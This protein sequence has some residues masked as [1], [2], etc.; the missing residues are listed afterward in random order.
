M[1]I[2]LRS[3]SGVALLGLLSLASVLH[4]AS[5]WISPRPAV[6]RALLEG[7]GPWLPVALG[8]GLVGALVGALLAGSGGLPR[9]GSELPGG[10]RAGGILALAG[11]L[12]V[13]VVAAFA[14]GGMP[15]HVD[16]VVQAFQARVL[17]E[18]AAVAPAPPLFEFF[19][20]LNTALD[21]DRW[22]GQFPPGFP[23]LLA[24]AGP[25][26]GRIVL[27]GALAAL[28][29]YALF[30][31]GEAVYGRGTGLLAAALFAFNPF[32]LLL[33]ASGLN[34][35]AAAA[36]A[37]LAFWLAACATGEHHG[38]RL[39][40]CGAALGALITIRPLDGLV[41]SACVLPYAL[42]SVGAPRPGGRGASPLPPQPS[43]HLRSLLCASAG[44]L[45][46]LAFL[47]LYNHATTGSAG[48]LGY[49]HV[50]GAA[51]G[52]GFHPSPWGEPHTLGSGLAHL[53]G[54]LWLLNARSFG[55]ALPLLPL[56]ALPLV[57]SRWGGKRR[58]PA[59]GEARASS[60]PAR[61]RARAERT[62]YLLALALPAAYVFYWH[63]DWFLGP[64]YL[65]TVFPFF[66]LLAA[67]GC[68]LLAGAAGTREVLRGAVA[69]A[70][71]AGALWLVA[72][73][74]PARL[75]SAF[76]MRP[77]FRVDVARQAKELG[78]RRG[79][80]FVKESWGSRLLA[81][82]RARG[83]TAAE[84]ERSYRT[85]DHCTLERLLRDPA[86]GRADLLAAVAT[87][88]RRT[89]PAAFDPRSNGDPSLRLRPGTELAPECRAEIAYDL[90]AP[91]G[92]FTPQ[93]ALLDPWLRE[94]VV[95][96]RDLGEADARLV[97]ALRRG[98][99]YLYVPGRG[100][101]AAAFLPLSAVSEAF[102]GLASG[103]L[104]G[105]P[106]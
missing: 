30:R 106:P 46:P 65:F 21:G 83:L 69:G 8:V 11:G 103:A 33:S 79:V 20:T 3:A 59:P 22:F 88:L 32:T 31:A 97:A 58:V 9:W 15:V 68:A 37:A 78:I 75:G 95:V 28:S 71:A 81:R 41:V 54:D 52:M 73:E 47:A 44:L 92:A 34:H 55:V 39:F 5:V 61:G 25:G 29:A 24:L 82:L 67:R 23:A 53:H 94:P 74:L 18:G 76:A 2:A 17:R 1:R 6:G 38:A 101:A 70:L 89:P 27:H 77:D 72:Q 100:A 99:G 64:R 84:T 63:H 14:F 51:H 66:C 42:R 62:L 57:F 96:A 10:R 36:C 16:G 90:A 35:A 40:G 50:W 105:D 48:E 91:Y 87:D 102:S 13:A 80:V 85:A 60:R 43:L 86:A 56:V 49:T 4:P 93:L 98:P 26:A 7:S 45:P 104:P 19:V 12:T